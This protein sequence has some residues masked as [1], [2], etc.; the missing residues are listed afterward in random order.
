MTGNSNLSVVHT[1][2]DELWR[3]G[4]RHVCISPGSRST[5]ITMSVAA[6]GGFTVHTL[7]DERSSAYFALGLA[8][9]LQ[10]PVLLVCTSGT[11]TAN[12]H[13]AVMEASQSR[14]PLLVL[15][16]DRPPELHYIGANQ[17]V[18]QT[19]MF[20]RH[21][22][23]SV[24][25]PVP[26]D[27]EAI[28]AYA[29]AT[30][31]RS[32]AVAMSAPM[33]PVH[34]NWPFREPL[35]PAARAQRDEQS[36]DEQAT[37]GGQK[38]G[39]DSCV[40]TMSDISDL[41][42]G[43]LAHLGLPRLE[44]NGKTLRSI[45]GLLA[46]SKRPLIVLGPQEDME[47]A[48]RVLS[49]ARRLGSPILADPLSQLRAGVKADDQK[50]IVDTYDWFLSPEFIQLQKPD[51]VLRFGRTPTSKG[52]SQYLG[53]LPHA[54]QV[55]CS[56]SPE[57]MDVS[58]RAT[59]V[60]VSEE[61]RFIER[62][63][64]INWESQVDESW[65]E[66]WHAF[67]QQVRE[68][69]LGI[70]LA[71]DS[72]VPGTPAAELDLP[73]E[74]RLW[75]ELERHLQGGRGINLFVGNSMPVRD[76]DGF[77]ATQSN[78]LRVFANRGVSGIDGIVSSA[79]GTSAA[80]REATVLIIGDVSFYHDLNGLLAVMRE[81]LPLCVILVHNDGGGIFTG[82]PQ[83]TVPET[84][85]YFQTPHGLDFETVVEMYGGLF[86]SVADWD[87]FGVVLNAA[88]GREGATVVE[89]RTSALSSTARRKLIRQEVRE[90]WE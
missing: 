11:A 34:I 36:G 56:V 8:R 2:I 72:S 61:G 64:S 13:P 31:W 68:I 41:A 59:H 45:E 50:F 55:V 62:L 83:T 51:V 71:Y 58:L 20:G 5:P 46:A 40:Q 53:S 63:L 25:M 77:F 19:G 90:R 43:G 87:E 42:R 81:K 76:M 35:V 73:F 28:H 67:N 78:P 1:F 48:Q 4:L 57:W 54:A 27:A 16:A 79:A 47:V 3:F 12:Y 18:S 39:A 49:L 24:E 65:L 84:F 66:A 52:L 30:A 26:E 7:L 69:A 85:E 80:L 38:V 74:G 23:W 10:A 6:H 60:C 88:I 15:T 22:K 82:L 14:V 86:K 89:L 44:P 33:G 29:A 70:A 75:I 37:T 32:T 21:V 17:T 9:R